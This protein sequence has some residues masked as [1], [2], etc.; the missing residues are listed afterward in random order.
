MEKALQSEEKSVNILALDVASNCG[1]A[2]TTSKPGYYIS[3]TWKLSPKKDESK[4]MR[5]I[6]LRSKLNEIKSTAEIGL[7]VFESAVSY[8]AKH[9]SGVTVQAE[10]LGVL[11]LWCEDHGIEYKGYAPTEIKKH[12]TGKGNA[13]KEMMLEAARKSFGDSVKDDNEADALW[14]L[15]LALSDLK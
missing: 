8:G 14:L 6:R 3:G 7:V 15:R 2:V 1:F 9:A 11:K 12:A 5:L 13:N 10:M 4:G